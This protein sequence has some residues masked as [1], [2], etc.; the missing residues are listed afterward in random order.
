MVVATKLRLALLW[1]VFA[2]FH[3]AVWAG[4][5][6]PSNYFSSQLKVSPSTGV[7]YAATFF[8]SA[9]RLFSW[10]I[11]LYP[12]ALHSKLALV[13]FI[14]VQCLLWGVFWLSAFLLLRRVIARGISRAA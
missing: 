6:Y 8:N 4:S 14:A 9:H 2:G 13:L 10:P 3:L 1:L 5:F 11:S 7:E 12:N